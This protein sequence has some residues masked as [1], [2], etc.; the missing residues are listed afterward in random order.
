MGKRRPRKDLDTS[1][2]DGVAVPSPAGQFRE[3][4]PRGGH[5]NLPAA[6]RVRLRDW[7]WCAQSGPL[8]PQC[9]SDTVTSP[10]TVVWDEISPRIAGHST[11][12]ELLVGRAGWSLRTRV[13]TIVFSPRITFEVRCRLLYWDKRRWWPGRHPVTFRQKQLWKLV[14][15]RR[16]LLATFADKVAVRDYVARAVG[17][18]VLTRLFA[19]VADPAA[20]DPIQL[21]AQF[22]VKPNHCS[23]LI[24]IVDRPGAHGVVTGN[25]AGRESGSVR[26]TRDELDWDQLVTTCRKWLATTYADVDLEWPYRHIP[27]RIL[28]EEL[29][30][31]PDGRIPTDYKFFVFHG[32]VR[33]VQVDTDRFDDHRRNLFL[34]D[35]TAVDARWNYPPADE[36][37]PRPESLE[38][39]IGMAEALGRE[40]DFVRVD[41]YDIA[42]RIVFGELTSYPGGPHAPPF[43]PES[44]DG[45]LGRHW[46]VPRR[47]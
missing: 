45:E 31:T 43:S 26:T 11:R 30:L 25:R 5:A 39:M 38:R 44:F 9:R 1:G 6:S 40:T 20:L 8:D 16:P 18:E 29:L 17:P 24:W 4:E 37:P 10:T 34:P 46:T 22:V 15:D 36:E 33:L 32:R 35:W 41:L 47:Y 3:P 42:G 21:P 14:K 7:S 2:P 28:V 19:V 27:R 13:R 23:G 12:W